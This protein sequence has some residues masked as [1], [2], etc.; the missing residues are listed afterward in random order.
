MHV[1]WGTG[2]SACSRH[3]QLDGPAL[4]SGPLTNPL[5]QAWFCPGAFKR[6]FH[7]FAWPYSPLL[8][9]LGKSRPPTPT[10]RPEEVQP[11]RREAASAVR[12]AGTKWSSTG[13]ASTGCRGTCWWRT[14]STS[15]SRS[16]QG[17]EG[18][19]ALQRR[20]A[21]KADVAEETGGLWSFR[22][23]RMMLISLFSLL[24]MQKG[25]VLTCM[26][27]C[28]LCNEVTSP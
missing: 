15:T 25:T 11:W 7:G 28:L 8:V 18:M 24:E 14:S 20:F 23:A 26:S 10:C 1:S 27:V 22:L 3:G 6:G 5:L 2:P 13:T 21:S 16:P 12:P 17:N 9:L 19:R 4:S